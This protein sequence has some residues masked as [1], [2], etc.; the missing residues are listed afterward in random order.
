MSVPICIVENRLFHSVLSLFSKIMSL[1]EFP[2][3]TIGIT[4]ISLSMINSISEVCYDLLMKKS[5]F[6][7]K[8]E[9]VN[10]ARKRNLRN[11][12]SYEEGR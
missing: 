6:Y 1:R 10:R 9:T 4:L 11:G 8:I 2:G 7:D 5:A 12:G 3:G